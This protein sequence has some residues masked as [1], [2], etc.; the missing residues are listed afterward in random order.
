VK[1][2]V[3]VGRDAPTQDRAGTQAARSFCLTNAASRFTLSMLILYTTLTA[4]VHAEGK[5]ELDI[6]FAANGRL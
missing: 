5:F 3:L 4:P 2:W 1:V 6:I